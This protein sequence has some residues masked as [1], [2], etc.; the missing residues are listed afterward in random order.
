MS[1]V[2]HAPSSIHCLSPTYDPAEELKW[3]IASIET[4]V[5]ASLQ[6]TGV[7]I[8]TWSLCPICKMLHFVRRISESCQTRTYLATRHIWAWL[9]EATK[10]A[11]KW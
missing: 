6:L 10:V 9:I 5:K 1:M 7:V 11:V 2:H 8:R 4:N 3:A